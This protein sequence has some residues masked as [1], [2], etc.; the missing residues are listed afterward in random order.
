MF[1]MALVNMP[2]ASL[3]RPSIALTQLGAV[4]DRT[5]GDRVTTTIL[6]V[7]Q[8]FGRLLGAERYQQLVT[9]M[10]FLNSGF[11]EWFF[12]QAAFPEQP[13]N[14]EEYFHRYFYQPTEETR[15]IRRLTGEVRPTV[16]ALLDRVIEVNRL[17]RV[18][19][20]GFTSMFS[21]NVASF[22]LARR[23]KA[24]N[25]DVTVIIGG[26]NC[27]APMGRAVVAN[28]PAVDFAFSGPALRTLPAFLGHLLDGDV[29]ACHRIDGVFSRHNRDRPAA[30]APVIALTSAGADRPQIGP[31][32]AELSIDEPVPLDYSPFIAELDGNFPRREVAPVLT[33]ETSRGCWWGERAHCTFCGLNGDSMG[34]RAM[35]AE[36]AIAL[37]SSLLVH[38]DRCQ[39]F[40]CVDNIMPR[41]HIDDVFPKL[42]VPEGTLLFYEIKADLT[43][44]QMRTLS[45]AG[46]RN[47]QPGI[48]AL[49]TST[50]KLMKK[51][52]SA[53]GN[54]R[55]LKDCV[56]SDLYPE[57]NLLVGFPGEM[58]A[59]YEKYVRDLP[60]LMHLPPP[61]GV[62]PVRF[63]RYSPY[64]TRAAEYGLD[65]APYDYYSL[66]YPFD[67]ASLGRLA[68]YFIDQNFSAPYIAMTARW[69]ARL[70]E[71]VEAWHT[72]WHRDT[73]AAIPRL[74]LRET[75][76]GWVVHDS[77]SGEVREERLSTLAKA[78]L[79]ALDKPTAL[80]SLRTAITASDDAFDEEIAKLRVRG[81]IYE[82]GER[83]ISLVFPKEPP[84]M[85]CQIGREHAARAAVAA[86]EMEPALVARSRDAHRVR[87]STIS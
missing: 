19:V 81:W 46:V 41:E 45:A 18:R 79:D 61:G 25:P 54:V 86:L 74:F 80:E 78:V 32:G 42:R 63:D 14:S 87:R 2:F 9:S 65:L 85:M 59:V 36:G 12:R 11:G 66:I 56:H 39:R 34:Y 1:S 68:Y 57:W 72:R 3:Q 49:A 31:V 16:N 29:E 76:D 53:L 27:E 38:A 47:V 26:A 40:E 82:E 21:Q 22:A 8:D 48:E 73:G 60:R 50:L 28:V 17:D 4:V 5:F 10:N 67:R 44:E 35:K 62:F 64:F 70:R 69:L 71:R 37:I 33:F 84:L 51:G 7:N 55:F 75:P 15:L 13:D 6:Y 83:A 77:R 24:C 58:E 20:L 30:G 52:T 43:A 23:V